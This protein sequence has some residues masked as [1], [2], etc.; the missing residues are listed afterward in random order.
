LLVA[1][2]RAAAVA[3]RTMSRIIAPMSAS[4]VSRETIDACDYG[5]PFGRRSPGKRLSLVASRI[6]VEAGLGAFECLA[7]LEESKELPLVRVR[8][9]EDEDAAHAFRRWHLA[10]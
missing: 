6:P 2:G 1:Y 5:V 3:A 9:I 8:V 10:R 7:A 4:P